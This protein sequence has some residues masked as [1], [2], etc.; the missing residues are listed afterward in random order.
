VNCKYAAEPTGV[1]PV[2]VSEGVSGPMRRIVTQFE[3]KPPTQG[4]E[5]DKPEA[6]MRMNARI[7]GCC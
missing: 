5:Y 7:Q 6:L 1:E 4:N 3:K 2:T